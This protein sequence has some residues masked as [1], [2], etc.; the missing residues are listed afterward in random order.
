MIRI[1]YKPCFLDFVVNS[2]ITLSITYLSSY[3]SK[4]QSIS[5]LEQNFKYIEQ[6]I[7][8]INIY[9]ESVLWSRIA[10]DTIN[11]TITEYSVITQPQKTD[12][13]TNIFVDS[14]SS[15]P[16]KITFYNSIGH[17]DSV[18]RINKTPTI[19]VSHNSPIAS[20]LDTT[21]VIYKYPL[22]SDKVLYRSFL[23]LRNGQRKYFRT[24]HYGYNN[25][26]RLILRID[27]DGHTQFYYEYN[28]KGELSAYHSH[29]K[30]VKLEYDEFGRK[31]T[32]FYTNTTNRYEYDNN[33]FL[34]RKIS[35]GLETTVYTYTY[36]K[37]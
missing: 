35:A 12:P 30:S 21:I 23:S 24:D 26:N 16:I 31:I 14:L 32:E 3:K 15:V 11:R 6:K 2:I 9:K 22:I 5:D 33:S 37:Y 29:E 19:Y 10:V 25:N 8:C 1:S 17:V 7:E 36:K 4:G 18:L 28:E 13:Y 27:G 34:I 20:R